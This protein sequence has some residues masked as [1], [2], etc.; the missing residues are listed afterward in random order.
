MVYVHLWN[1]KNLV[2]SS[3]K[4]KHVYNAHTKKKAL[5]PKNIFY[6]ISNI[7]QKLI[8]KFVQYLCINKLHYYCLYLKVML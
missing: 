3:F 4:A 1:N 5:A 2:Q 7:A 6:T 8:N